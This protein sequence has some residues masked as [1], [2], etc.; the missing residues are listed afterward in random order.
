MSL[1]GLGILIGLAAGFFSARAIAGFLQGVSATDL[2]TFTATIGML[3]LV[4]LIACAIPARRAI[5]VNPITALR[6]E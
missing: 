2:P 6:H 4:A 1:V 3:A 5:R